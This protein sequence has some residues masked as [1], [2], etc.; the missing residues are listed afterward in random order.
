MCPEEGSRKGGRRGLSSEAK[1]RGSLSFTAH[2]A[3]QSGGSVGCSKGGERHGGKIKRRG[4]EEG[5]LEVA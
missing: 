4:E 5:V 1:N 2:D 3:L